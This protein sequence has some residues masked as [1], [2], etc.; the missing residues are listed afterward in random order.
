MYLMDPNLINAANTLWIIKYKTN[1]KCQLCSARTSGAW[2]RTCQLHMLCNRCGIREKK[3]N[4]N[5]HKCMLSE[6]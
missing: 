4:I 5:I 1:K 3:K 2:R 6:H